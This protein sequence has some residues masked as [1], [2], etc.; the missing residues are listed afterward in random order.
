LLFCTV[1]EIK[2]YDLQKEQ[3]LFKINSF[4]TF[5]KKGSSGKATDIL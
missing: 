2:D 3:L 4:S 5:T 1:T